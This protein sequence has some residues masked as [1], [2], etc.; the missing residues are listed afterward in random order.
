MVLFAFSIPA[1]AVALFVSFAST[2]FQVVNPSP[3]ASATPLLPASISSLE[4]LVFDMHAELDALE[5]EPIVRTHFL[6]AMP[7]SGPANAVLVESTFDGTHTDT[8]EEW[9]VCFAPFRSLC[10]TSDPVWLLA[11]PAAVILLYAVAFAASLDG[12][13]PSRIVV[14]AAESLQGEELAFPICNFLQLDNAKDADFVVPAEDINGTPAITQLVP[15]VALAVLPI[16]L[17]VAEEPALSVVPPTSRPTAPL[18]EEPAASRTL[19]TDAVRPFRRIDRVRVRTEGPPMPPRASRRVRTRTAPAHMRHH[20]TESM[21]SAETI[22]TGE[23]EAQ[24]QVDRVRSHTEM[25]M[26]LPRVAPRTRTRTAPGQL[27]LVPAPP[28]PAG[29]AVRRIFPLD[30]LPVIVGA[31]VPPAIV[32]SH[33]TRSDIPG[34][35]IYE[36]PAPLFHATT[37]SSRDP[38]DRSRLASTIVYHGRSAPPARPHPVYQHPM[39]NRFVHA[40]VQHYQHHSD[41]QRRAAPVASKTTVL[42]GGVMLGTAPRAR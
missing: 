13:P 10:P 37:R 32:S 31:P 40:Q 22:L 27:V 6:I 4:T 34:S 23:E 19:P 24:R 39:L 28:T 41:V 18:V 30:A 16:A 42:T 25:P 3:S 11:L 15:R 2:V 38:R 20:P 29:A 36:T 35:V 5:S 21:G 33:G 26:T 17:G 7:D 1:L 9:V 8:D 14:S 12:D